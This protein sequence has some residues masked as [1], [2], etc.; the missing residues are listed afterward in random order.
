MPVGGKPISMI[1]FRKNI[2]AA[3]LAALTISSVGVCSAN[4]ADDVA[5]GNAT[6]TTNVDTRVSYTG[7]IIDCRGLGLKTAMSPVVMDN[8]GN[9]IYGFKDIDYDMATS[10]GMA[11]Y[12]DGLFDRHAMLR[13]GFNP[14]IIKAVDVVN[15]GTY[16]VI[17]ETDA[18]LMQYSTFS[19]NYFKTASVVFV[20]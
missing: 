20:R 2:I 17:D 14:I 15:H 5:M 12:A 19:N 4:L 11:G 1:N 10:K 7:A 13:A 6:Y 8:K 16:P 18:K 9:K 3:A